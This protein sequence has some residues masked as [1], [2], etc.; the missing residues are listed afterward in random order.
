MLLQ[1]EPMD[2]SILAGIADYEGAIERAVTYA[3]DMLADAE[4]ELTCLSDTPYKQAFLGI[5]TYLRGLLANCLIQQTR[6]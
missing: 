4:S 3:S 6:P 2:T 1:G 5:A